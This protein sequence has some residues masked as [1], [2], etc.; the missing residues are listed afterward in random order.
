ME[1]YKRKI[2]YE[3]Y[4][5]FSGESELDAEQALNLFRSMEWRKGAFLSFDLNPVNSFQ[6]MC[7]DDDKFLAE[8]TNDSN[9]MIFLQKYASKQEAAE[10][11]AHFY[12]T[13]DI[14]TVSGFHEVPVTSKTLDQVLKGA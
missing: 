9:E 8:I 12:T 5:R 11:I 13:N 4:I 1:P 7:Q 10:L 3:D 6:V 2:R 14:A